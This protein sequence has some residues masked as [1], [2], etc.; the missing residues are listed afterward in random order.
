[1]DKINTLTWELK[2]Q[3]NGLISYYIQN[4]V[5]IA[6]AYLIAE[7]ATKELELLLAQSIQEESSKNEKE[8]KEK[9]E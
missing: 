9:D 3:L 2:T 7:N 1:M 6:S 8:E 5:S 4:G